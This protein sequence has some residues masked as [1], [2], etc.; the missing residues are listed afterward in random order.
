MEPTNSSTFERQHQQQLSKTCTTTTLLYLSLV[1]W[2]GQCAL[3]EVLVRAHNV[4][5]VPGELRGLEYL[6]N[7]YGSLP[8][9]QILSSSIT[10]ARDGFNVTKDLVNYM[11]SADAA[12]QTPGFLCSDPAWAIDFCPNGTRLGLGD[13]ITRKRYAAT[14]QTIADHGV[15]AFYS[16]QYPPLPPFSAYPFQEPSQTQQLLH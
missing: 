16:G 7:R 8:W 10:V 2:P 11:K 4:S 12:A 9:K 3:S 1:V 5:G 13:I 6:H 15:N 14:L